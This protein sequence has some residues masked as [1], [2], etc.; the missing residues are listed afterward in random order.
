[1][2]RDCWRDLPAGHELDALVAERVLGWQRR[3]SCWDRDPLGRDGK[4]GHD[5][6][7]RGKTPCFSSRWDGAGLV[8]EA[9]ENRGW[10]LNLDRPP[11]LVSTGPLA[12]VAKIRTSIGDRRVGEAADTAPLA[13]CRAALAALE[14]ADV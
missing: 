12:W 3:P 10:F 8:V 7:S 1:M 9:M 13:I 5:L 2:A 14:S 4:P 11:R 6:L